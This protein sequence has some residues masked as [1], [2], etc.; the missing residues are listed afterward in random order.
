MILQK[1]TLSNN[2]KNN[3]SIFFL[4]LLYLFLIKFFKKL[5]SFFV[6]QTKFKKY[7]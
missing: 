1:H 5:K 3:N 7:A 6:F 2:I 4:N